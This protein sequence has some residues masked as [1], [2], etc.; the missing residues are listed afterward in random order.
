MGKRDVE[1]ERECKYC[2][3]FM[4]RLRISA[5]HVYKF[6]FMYLACLINY[7]YYGL[8]LICGRQR[9]TQTSLENKC[10]RGGEENISV[11]C[12]KHCGWVGENCINRK[13]CKRNYCTVRKKE[14]LCHENCNFSY[15]QQQ[16]SQ[17]STLSVCENKTHFQ[18]CK[19]ILLNK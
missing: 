19:L 2:S 1:G 9:N 15:W 16:F 8:D 18:L 10:M 7:K 4:Y 13:C 17:F 6:V 3:Q 12:S 11:S 14:K 5:E